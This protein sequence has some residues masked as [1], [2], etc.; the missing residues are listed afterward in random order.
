[1]NSCRL[2]RKLTEGG[3]KEINS[4][5]AKRVNAIAAQLLADSE[6]KLQITIAMGAIE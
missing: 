1:M 5:R 2:L 4:F 3:C 6:E